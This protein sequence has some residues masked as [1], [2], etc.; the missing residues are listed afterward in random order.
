M[1]KFEA[2]GFNVIN[3]TPFLQLK[4]VNERSKDVP[5]IGREGL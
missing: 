4:K 5:V 2:V 3:F 1:Y